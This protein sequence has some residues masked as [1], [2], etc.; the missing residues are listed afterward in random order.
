MFFNK[1]KIFNKFDFILFIIII[2][3]AYYWHL[4]YIGMHQSY[5]SK[6][7]INN[8]PYDMLRTNM[9]LIYGLFWSKNSNWRRMV[10]GSKR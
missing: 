2:I 7:K 6:I 10:K 4:G 5:S 3:A 8:L 9:R 1:T